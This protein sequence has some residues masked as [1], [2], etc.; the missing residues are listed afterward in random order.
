VKDLVK[1][2]KEIGND[3]AKV[4]GGLV[5]SEGMLKAEVSVNY[6]LAQIV[7]PVTSLLDKAIDKLKAAIPGEWDD[8]LLDKVKSEYK[9]E[10]SKFLS[11]V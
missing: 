10:L 9:D 1:F 4:Q 7:E 5:I 8:A 11:G 3:G 6:P 2:E